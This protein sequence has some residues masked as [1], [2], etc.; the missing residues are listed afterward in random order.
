[1][2]DASKLN[3]S[4]YDSRDAIFIENSKYV[5]L[6]DLEVK[7]AYRA[8]IR[9]STSDHITIRNVTSHNNGEWGIFTDFSN[10]M[11]IVKCVVYGSLGQHGIYLSNSGDY[12]IVRNC[13]IYNNKDCGIHI[14]GDISMGGDGIISHALIEDNIIHDNGAS[15]G[16]GINC[17]G[18]TDSV[19]RDNLLYNNHASGI[20]LY[21]IDGGAPS[22]NNSIYQNTVIVASDGRWA[23]NMKDGSSQNRVY[24]NVLLNNNSLHGSINTDSIVGLKSDY[25]ILTTNNMVASPDNDNTYLNFTQWQKL[26]FDKHS[27]Q[28]TSTKIFNNTLLNKYNL[29]NNSTAIDKGTSLYTAPTDIIG[30]KRPQDGFSIGAYEYPDTIKPTATITPLGGTYNNTITITLKMSEPG[31]IYYTLNGS[32]PTTKYTAPFQ[33]SKTTTINYQAIDK[34]GNK[35]PI[36]TVTYNI[37]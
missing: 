12:P 7:N 35:S 30:V 5:I 22:N 11:L 6:E 8:G 3:G 13:T 29:K 27:L 15:G 4:T 28:S 37:K 24:N 9:V 2:I 16:S 10:Y 36:Y 23:L 31:T 32:T 34:V 19:I 1:M 18:V 25:N 20:S 14:N 33:L 26:G 21:Q 17:D